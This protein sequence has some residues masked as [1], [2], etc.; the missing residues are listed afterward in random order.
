MARTEPPTPRAAAS[1]GAITGPV[2]IQI[3]CGDDAEAGRIAR[4]LVER[5]L[6][7]CVQRLPIRSTYRWEGEVVDDDEVLLLVKTMA[8]RFDGIVATV[9]ELH[10]YELPA[11]SVVAIAGGSIRYLD[12]IADV[13]R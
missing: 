1:A 12:W 13:T 5:R 10:S 9:D 2:E 11:V 4:A 8:D 7:A 6:A 3:A